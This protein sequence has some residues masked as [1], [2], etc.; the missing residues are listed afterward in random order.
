MSDD[1]LED[2]SII[3]NC[4]RTGGGI[5]IALPSRVIYYCPQRMAWMNYR[6]PGAADF[7][8]THEFGHLALESGDESLV[9]CWAAQRFRSAEHGEF[10]IDSVTRFIKRYHRPSKKYGTP[11]S[12]ADHIR[13]CFES[14]EMITRGDEPDQ[15]AEESTEAE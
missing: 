8:M 9:D 11:E 1:T 12:R 6:A 4:G 13:E 2:V 15:R 3:A 7:F 5:A 10:Y 14:A